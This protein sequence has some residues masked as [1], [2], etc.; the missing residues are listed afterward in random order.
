MAIDVYEY[1]RGGRC[2][3]IFIYTYAGIRIIKM[4]ID[5]GDRYRS[6]V[7]R[8]SRALRK[9]YLLNSQ[10]NKTEN[11]MVVMITKL[12]T[13]YAVRNPGRNTGREENIHTQHRLIETGK[14][15]RNGREGDR[16]YY[17]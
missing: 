2:I 10:K 11:K 6:R 12:N 15:T 7:M 4:Q 13:N 9:R 8:T 5:R 3:C 1:G 14:Q 16:G 17:C